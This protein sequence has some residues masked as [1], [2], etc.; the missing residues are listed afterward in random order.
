MNAT[1][2]GQHD[3][4]QPD[5]GQPE[6]ATAS[7]ERPPLRRPARGRML[8]GVSV[9]IGRHF[10]IDVTIVRIVFAVLTILGFTGVP[11]LGDV[12]F[13]LGGIPLYL[14]CWLLIP[15]EGSDHSI[16]SGLLRN[17]QSRS[18]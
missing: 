18:R 17:L 4:D 14:A 7:H 3:T 10:N 12:P 2:D 16:A 11:F 8:A 6:P 13:Y 1:T 9:A 5:L 15:E